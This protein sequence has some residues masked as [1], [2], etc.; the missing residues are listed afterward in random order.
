MIFM[1]NSSHLSR[2]VNHLYHYKVFQSVSLSI[3][4][5][6]ILLVLGWGI[7]GSP[8]FVFGQMQNYTFLMSLDPQNSDED[9]SQEDN[10][11]DTD[12]LPQPEGID[13]DSDG[14]VLVNDI[15]YNQINL[16]DSTGKLTDMWGSSGDSP[17][18]FNHPHGNENDDDKKR[19][20]NT[21]NQQASFI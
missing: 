3:P 14:N 4:I 17:G 5:Y 16:F 8:S 1:I 7:G 13:V 10:S 9:T 6:L 21:S 11:I 2:G 20:N 15:G 18:Q 19:G 12:P